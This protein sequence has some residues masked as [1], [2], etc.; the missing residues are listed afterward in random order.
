MAFELSYAEHFVYDM[1][2]LANRRP[3]TRQLVGEAFWGVGW[4]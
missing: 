4:G 3:E 1:S 2:L